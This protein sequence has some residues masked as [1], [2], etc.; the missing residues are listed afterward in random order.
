M[1]HKLYCYVDE[2]GQDTHGAFFLVAIVLTEHEGLAVLEKQLLAIE[3]SGR[4]RFLKWRKLSFEAKSELLQQLA[5]RDAP[6]AREISGSLIRD[7][8]DCETDVSAFRRARRRLL[9]ALAG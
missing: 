5:S 9:E 2:T 8:N 4:G 6:Q 3:S 7:F 1:T